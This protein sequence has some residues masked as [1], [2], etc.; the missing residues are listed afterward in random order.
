MATGKP[1]LSKINEALKSGF[2]KMDTTLNDIL[3]DNK[4]LREDISEIRNVIIKNL[5]EANGKLQ[6]RVDAMEAN[7]MSLEYKLSTELSQTNQYGRRNN[8][9]ICGIPNSISDEMLEE[10]VIELFSD[11][12]VEVH[13]TEI[14]AC[15]RLPPARNSSNK[16]VIV[17]FSN[18]K[19]AEKL[20]KSKKKLSQVRRYE[21][22]IFINENLNKNFQKIAWRC[23]QLKKAKLIELFKFQ[24]ESFII[25]VNH[26]ER[27]LKITSEKDILNFFPDYFQHEL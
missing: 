7:I 27:P 18:R 14:E 20:L 5:V 8:I 6:K 2:A 13:H 23:R 26:N 1:T 24:N 17:R 12:E 15:H 4:S 16:K 19:F 3:N 10:E 9:E 11:I 21:S 22:K 25:Q